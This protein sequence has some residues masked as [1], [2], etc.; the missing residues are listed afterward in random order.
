MILPFFY[1]STILSPIIN[2]HW[3]HAYSEYKILRSMDMWK[4]RLLPLLASRT[5]QGCL[6]RFS[7]QTHTR[8]SPRTHVP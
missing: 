1:Q 3:L 2:T 4:V 8:S 7:H 6:A 5:L